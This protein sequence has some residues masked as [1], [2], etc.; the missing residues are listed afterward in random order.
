[1]SELMNRILA[2]LLAL[3]ACAHAAPPHVEF[4]GASL[5]VRRLFAPASGEADW[6]DK[7][8]LATAEDDGAWTA[9]VP[10]AT[11][12]HAAK[13][14]TVT[15]A[16]EATGK[17]DG[18][19][20]FDHP[21]GL[22]ILLVQRP[23]PS[24]PDGST[25]FDALDETDAARTMRLQELL[26]AAPPGGTVAVAPGAHRVGTIFLRPGVRLHLTRGAVLT[27]SPDTLLYPELP[28]FGGM[29]RALIV[30][31]EAHGASITGPGVIDGQGHRFRRNTTETRHPGTRLIAA[32]DTKVL[33]IED[34][35][36]IDSFAWAGH[37]Q[38]CD[39]LTIRRAS[40]INE[41]NHPGWSPKGAHIVW[42]NADGLNPDGCRGVLFEDL[43]IHAGDD[44]VAVKSMDPALAPSDVTVRRSV[45]WTPVA[46]LKVGTES[47]GE[48]MRDIHF[49][50]IHIARCGR[51]FALDIFDRARASDITF[52]DITVARADQGLLFRA[53]KR[54]ADQP[55]AGSLDG[56]RI[57]NIRFTDPMPNSA[58]ETPHVESQIGRV[59][60]RNWSPATNAASVLMQGT[61]RVR[62]L[63]FEP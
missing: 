42:N 24:P 33:T 7:V 17:S 22:V 52:R 48:T 39:N 47:R 10:G 30:A 53:G 63:V 43:L 50:D 31:I 54:K 58:F 36:L 35:V 11:A 55:T 40:V 26:D 23:D 61:D 12:A 5:E 3:S 19:L 15:S 41:I 8:F 56:V 2:S 27:A 28:N 13:G 37:F 18:R 25:V 49:E 45:L 34:A 16:D 14:V 44:C 57:E 51:A 21:E 46:A 60:I 6:S 9:K 29:N 4:N 38:N 59:E 1:M 62:E 20:G 32:R